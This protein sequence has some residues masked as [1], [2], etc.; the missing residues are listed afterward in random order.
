[1]EGLLGVVEAQLEAERRRSAGQASLGK[2]A[3]SEKKN[4]KANTFTLSSWTC[5]TS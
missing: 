4:S 2:R 3:S 5:R 1:M